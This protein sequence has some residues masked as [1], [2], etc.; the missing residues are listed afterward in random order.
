MRKTTFLILD[1]IAKNCPTYNIKFKNKIKNIL[2][3]AMLA[4]KADL[5]KNFKVLLSIS[6]PLKYAL[7]FYDPTER[8]KKS[9]KLINF[10]L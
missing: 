3:I 2:Y 10:A 4:Q 1:F 9:L 7:T 8:M 6:L 5:L